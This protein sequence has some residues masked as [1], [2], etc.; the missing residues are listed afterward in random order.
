MNKPIDNG[1]DFKI[2]RR[3]FFKLAATTGVVAAAVS[4]NNDPVETIIP[5]INPPEGLIAGKVYKF[6]SHVAGCTAG[7]GVLLRVVDGRIIGVEGN[8]ANP[9]NKGAIC[10]ICQ[11]ALQ[12]LYSPG[13]IKSPLYNNVSTSWDSALAKL[14]D[15]FKAAEGRVLYIGPATNSQQHLLVSEYFDKINADQI[16]F[17]ANPYNNLLQA[18]EQIFG[19]KE[20]PAFDFTQADTLLSIGA[21]FLESWHSVVE[22]SGKYADFRTIKNGKK[23]YHIH[24]SPQ[25]SLTAANADTWVNCRSKS[26]YKI[27]LAIIAGLLK[28]AKISS[29]LKSTIESKIKAVNYAEV[30]DQDIS[31]AQLN[32]IIDA[33]S[34]GRAVAISGGLSVSNETS[35][36]LLQATNI[37]NYLS[38]AINK[39]VNFGA[40]YNFAG[41]SFAEVERVLAK[42]NDSQYDL[43][44][45]HNVNIL[46]SLPGGEKLKTA[47]SQNVKVTV[48][49]FPVHNETTAVCQ[50]LLPTS[51]SFESFDIHYP[52]ADVCTLQQ[53]GTGPLPG[54]DSKPVAEI[55]MTIFGALGVASNT[56]ATS[57]LEYIQKHWANRF[58][59][60]KAAEFTKFWQESLR[61]G[62]NYKTFARKEAS[63]NLAGLEKINF[64]DV[65]LAGL[66][67]VTFN[68]NFTNINAN[69]GNRGWLAEV[70][71]PVSQLTWDSWAEIN[72]KTAVAMGIEHGDEVKITTAAGSQKLMAYVYHGVNPDVVAIPAG[73][74]L[75]MIM[76]NYSSRRGLGIPFTKDNA[77]KLVDI[78]VGQNS[79]E[80]LSF[81][82][83]SHDQ[84]LI[85]PVQIEKTGVK[86]VFAAVDGQYRDSIKGLIAD[87]PAGFGDRSQKDRGLFQYV[88]E[89]D[90]DTEV[91]S[92]HHISRN[93]TVKEGS[94]TDF[95]NGIETQVDQ[96]SVKYGFILNT[97]V[98]YHDPYRFEMVIDLNRCTGCSSCIT[99]CY[100]ENNIPVVGKERVSLGRHMQWMRLE[101]Y[102]EPEE[103]GT[104]RAAFGPSSCQQCSNAG[105]EPV[106]PVFA[107]YHNPDGLNVQVYNRCVGTRYCANN[108]VYKQRRFNW[109]GYTFPYP[110][111]L[112]LNPEVSVRTKGVMEK[113][114]FC[115]Q[116]I[117]RAK[118]DAKYEQRLVQEGEVKTACQSACPTNAIS[119]GNAVDEMSKVS[120]LKKSKRS[121]IQLE[122][123]N[124]KPAVTYLRR[125]ISDKA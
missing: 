56:P 9:L 59:T 101:R 105:C 4:C 21:D 2:G 43:V 98:P 60:G 11:S 49:L 69:T 109:R 120:L 65:S 23:G 74:G 15:D 117:T 39:S 77:D 33:F 13:R 25:L 28:N 53:P 52:K 108:C 5:L 32:K 44:V 41:S 40:G 83:A 72:P 36:M 47:L 14:T 112:Q 102:F 1:K 82:V 20:I 18:N 66:Q 35:L 121:Y 42:L 48:G 8:P 34:S 96:K 17:E 86:A 106:C 27:A 100:S 91:E 22:N 67:L 115:V 123:T 19:K 38:G 46:N 118:E 76:P 125:V 55:A 95:Y 50:V 24:I 88:K 116:R 90:A 71:Q 111:N 70:P 78:K 81:G 119:F 124:F 58:F 85:S 68:T 110:L 37:I 99:A 45:I 84:S 113:C 61:F 114:T 92:I 97:K 3:D 75:N 103:D 64:A 80:L 30:I 57:Y 122:E 26:E 51:T 16:K 31:S 89:A 29:S 63:L 104:M 87:S 94:V 73:Y 6:A 93:Y 54:I 7:C 10:S 12:E 79:M 62:G 107:T